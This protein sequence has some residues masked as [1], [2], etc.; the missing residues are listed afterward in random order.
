MDPYVQPFSY[1]N[2]MRVK[3][4]TKVSP[5]SLVLSRQLPVS[6][7]VSLPKAQPCD[8]YKLLT[9]PQLKVRLISGLSHLYRNSKYMLRNAQRSY[10]AACDKT[11]RFTPSFSKRHLEHV[12]CPPTWVMNETDK[13][14]DE[15]M[16]KLMP[17]TTGP[18]QIL[19]S[20]TY[21]VKI[22]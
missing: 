1:E 20:P 16:L 2:N 21:P 17:K 10:K 19:Q 3:R 8:A 5:L 6:A 9:E 22:Y 4:S 13:L 11:V 12:D 7:G 15:T 14:V 18:F